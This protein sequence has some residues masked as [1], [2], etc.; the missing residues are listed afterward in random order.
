MGGLNPEIHILDNR[1]TLKQGLQVASHLLRA[2]RHTILPAR[3]H[4]P[5]SSNFQPSYQEQDISRHRLLQVNHSSRTKGM[6]IDLNIKAKI[7][8]VNISKLH[9]KLEDQ[10]AVEDG[11]QWL[12]ATC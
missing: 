1:N 7:R 11:I 6:V 9:R 5:R 2:I 3:F 4:H 8:M 10:W 12:N